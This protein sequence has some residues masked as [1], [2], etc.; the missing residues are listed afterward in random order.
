[1]QYPPVADPLILRGTTPLAIHVQSQRRDKE[2]LF[3]T[4]HTVAESTRPVAA[5]GAG[6]TQ[7]SAAKT[8]SAERSHRIA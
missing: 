3:A 5:S 6:D 2:K 1:M 8:I 4:H 7:S